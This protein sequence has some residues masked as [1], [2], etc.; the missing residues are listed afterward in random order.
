VALIVVGVPVPA[1]SAA[2]FSHYGLRLSGEYSGQGITKVSCI[3]SLPDGETETYLAEGSAS[4]S[5]KFRTTTVGKVT[6]IPRAGPEPEMSLDSKPRVRLDVTR[7]NIAPDGCAPAPSDSEPPPPSTH[8]G[9]DSAKARGFL[10]IDRGRRGSSALRV[11]AGLVTLGSGELLDGF[12][13]PFLPKPSSLYP[14]CLMPNG[15]Q[16][17]TPLTECSTSRTT[18]TLRKRRLFSGANRI[19]LTQRTE[20]RGAMTDSRGNPVAGGGAHF[21]CG[22]AAASSYTM[23]VRITLTRISGG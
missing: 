12:S 20:G 5:T 11:D 10:G 13:D 2:S 22:D 9:T 23:I 6:F 21:R 4:E 1:A 18:P 19:A 7:S 15:Q 16:W 3:R 17:M 14:R 8:C